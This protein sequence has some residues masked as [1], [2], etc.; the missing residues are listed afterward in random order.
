MAKKFTSI[1]LMPQP[2]AWI[3]IPTKDYRISKYPITNAQF[4]QFVEADGYNNKTWW[5]AQGWETRHRSEWTA[6][7]AWQNHEFNGDT[8][9]VVGVS[10]FEA[11]AFCLWLRD[12]TGEKIVLPTEE[13]WQFT[14]QG[15]DGRN[16]PWGNQWDGTRCYNGVDNTPHHTS[17]VTHYDG[18]GDSPF[19]V[20]D[21]VGNVWEWCLTDFLDKSNDVQSQA[22]RRVLRGG[23]WDSQFTYFF[24]IDYRLPMI[25]HNRHLFV[26][27]RIV[28]FD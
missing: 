28:R 8:Q 15:D 12:M 20:M 21:M 4:A 13:Q 18:Q 24:H 5:T 6:P 25:P 10:W 14:A 1:D 26:G 2:F 16:Y 11:V 23:S 7:R 22:L 19:G 3:D 27:F 17:P 9:P